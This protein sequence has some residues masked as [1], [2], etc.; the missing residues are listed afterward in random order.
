MA[1]L[2]FRNEL[3]KDTL[4]REALLD[5]C[6][7]DARREK[8][9]ERLREGR[10]PAAGLAFTASDRGRLIGTVR[11]W[12]VTAGPKQ[13]A[14]LLGPLAVDP[15]FLNRGVGGALMRRAIAEAGRLGHGA[16]LLMG[17]ASFYGR[18]GFSAE[19]T[20]MLWMPG[21]FEPHRLLAL[22]LALGALDGAAGLIQPAGKPLRHTAPT[23]PTEQPRNPSTMPRA[24]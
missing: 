3:P 23:R 22:E 4:A 20:S 24:A 5:L 16:V 11:L 12:S 18:F 1:M 10:L 7:G 8:A 9:S 19:K 6:F 15:R 17:D 13:R 21:R 2:T 14:L